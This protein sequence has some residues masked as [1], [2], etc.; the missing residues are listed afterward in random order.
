MK[1]LFTV[2]GSL[3]I[4]LGI[5]IAILEM[6]T[7]QARSDRMRR[8]SISAKSIISR[9]SRASLIIMSTGTIFMMVAAAI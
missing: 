5:A 1:H 3:L 8:S 4:G 6:L 9:I 2:L 7:T